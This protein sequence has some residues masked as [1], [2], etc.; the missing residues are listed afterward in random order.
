MQADAML[1]RAYSD[2][3]V[4]EASIGSTNTVRVPKQSAQDT[5]RIKQPCS[6]QKT[7]CDRSMSLHVSKLRGISF[8][9]RAKLK[10]N[11]VTYTHQLLAAAGQPSQRCEFS[12][13]SGIEEPTLARLTYRADLARIKGIGAIFADMLELLSVDRV[14]TLADQK[15]E[16][17]HHALATLNSA[18]RFARRA[19]TP[20]EV[21]D[22]VLQ[23]RQLPQLVAAE[24]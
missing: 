13:K 12:E 4:S 1:S 17:L 22:W 24:S 11:G 15:P 6:T 23:A 16:V 20:E 2:E 5:R 19:P 10:R 3:M 14:A 9:V 8:D 18:E 21:E 7:P